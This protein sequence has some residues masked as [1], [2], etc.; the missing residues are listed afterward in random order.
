M[1]SHFSGS[2]IK[3]LIEHAVSQ[4]QQDFA[5]AICA[6]DISPNALVKERLGVHV[7]PEKLEALEKFP[8]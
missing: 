2:S 8:L 6:F 7:G 3:D 1:C 5:C 4:G